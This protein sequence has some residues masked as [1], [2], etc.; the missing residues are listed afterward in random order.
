MA[1][2]GSGLP[3]ERLLAPGVVI[4]VAAAAAQDADY[5]LTAEDV[6]AWERARGSIPAGAIAPIDARVDVHG[7]AVPGAGQRHRR[8]ADDVDVGPRVGGPEL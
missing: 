8:S 2:M 7:G 3:V 4:D 5:R 1:R 6:L